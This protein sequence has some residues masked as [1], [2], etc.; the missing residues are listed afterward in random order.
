MDVNSLTKED[1]A[2]FRLHGQIASTSIAGNRV[3]FGGLHKSIIHGP[4]GAQ[5]LVRCVCCES[6]DEDDDENHHGVHIIRQ[7]RSLDATKHGVQHDA[8]RQ[9]KASCSCRNAS[10]R[11]DHC[12][13]TGQ[14]H[15]GD[16]HV[17]HESK[18]NVNAVG[19]RAVT[20]ANDLEERVRV[21]CF[22]LQFDGEGGKQ[23]DL[24]RGSRGVPERSRHAV[25]VCN[26]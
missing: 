4:W 10:E 23:D 15:G 26:R 14:E 11:G 6:E 2:F 24:D 25:V 3:P 17:C 22:A 19:H 1:R 5:D 18:G 12:R 9:Q 13:A 16:E 21:R 20:S 8:D 7:E